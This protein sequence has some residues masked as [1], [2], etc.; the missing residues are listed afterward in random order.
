MKY[1]KVSLYILSKII[2]FARKIYK[3]GF[4]LLLMGRRKVGERARVL[5]DFIDLMIIKTINSSKEGLSVLELV[6]KLGLRHKNLKPHMDKLITLK[7]IKTYKDREGKA[8]LS[9][10]SKDLVLL[11]I[12]YDMNS[13][14]GEKKKLAEKEEALMKYLNEAYEYLK[15]KDNLDLIDIDLRK[16]KNIETRKEQ[17]NPKN[18]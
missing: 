7:L 9:T 6:D 3:Y 15:N 10:A 8:I 18:K 11:K 12:A 2:L 14:Y 4:T 5:F 1:L 16:T 13:A 17:Q